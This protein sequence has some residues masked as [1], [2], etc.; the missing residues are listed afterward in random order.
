MRRSG[1]EREGVV[2]ETAVE[3]LTARAGGYRRISR[4][5]IALISTS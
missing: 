2:N 3:V 1:G 5:T 4:V